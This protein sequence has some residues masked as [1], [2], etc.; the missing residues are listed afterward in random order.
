M[1]LKEISED[2]YI[3]DFY[4]MQKIKYNH[5]KFDA[6]ICTDNGALDYMQKYGKNIFPKVPVVCCGINYVDEKEIK[7]RDTYKIVMENIDI[8]AMLNNISIL[9]PKVKSLVIFGGNTSSGFNDLEHMKSVSQNYKHRF[10]FEFYEDTPIEKVKDIILS[11]NKDTAAIFM[12]DPMRDATGNPK[13]I[14]NI[15]DEFFRDTP[16]PIF[17]FWDFDLNYGILGGNLTSGYYQGETASKIALK[18][19]SGDSLSNID[20]TWASPNRYMFDY[21][22]LKKFNVNLKNLPK[23]SII[24][25][26]PF[27][28]YEKY[29]KLVLLIFLVLIIT[30]LMILL[31]LKK[32]N[33]I[34]LSNSYDELSAVYEELSATEEELRAQYDELQ[35]NEDLIRTREEIYRLA[36]N[37]ANDAIWQWNIKENY[38][39]ISDK[40][41]EFTGHDLNLSLKDIYDNFVLEEDKE[42]IKKHLISTIYGRENYYKS[43]I[44]LKTKNDNI[45]WFL[46]KGEV[47]RDN[48]GN[49]LMMAGSFTDISERKIKE[50]QIEK[51][52][53]YDSLT[54]LPNRGLFMK[55]LQEQ[56][57]INKLENKTGAIM[58]L[59]LDE[60]KKIN[61]TLGHFKGDCLLKIISYKLTFSIPK[62][63]T[64]ARFGG[65]EFL[66]LIPEVNNKMELE[67]LANQLLKIIKE[68]F[69]LGD[70]V[71]YVTSSI[72]IAVFP[73]DG[74]SGDILLKN[75][76]T[77]MYNAKES[78]KNRYCFFKNIMEKEI[79]RKA[80]VEN[81]LRN[82]LEN[83]EFQVYYQPQINMKSGEIIG[84]EALLRWNSKELGNISPMEFI[85]LAEKTGFIIP[86]G[87]WVLETV[88]KQNE[89]WKDKGYKYESIAVNVSMV[90][91]IQWDFIEN[92]KNILSIYNVSPNSLELEITENSLL[93]CTEENFK[94]IEDLRALGIKISLD[95]FGTGYSSL[96]YLRMFSINTV[97][98]DKS[99]ISDIANKYEQKLITEV[100]INLSHK[101]D[102]KVVAEGIENKE[103]LQL[104][105]SM[106][107]DFA[108]G[109]YFSKAANYVDMENLLKNNNFK[110]LIKD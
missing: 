2:A 32:K 71:N 96:N 35:K 14:A 41:T 34:A 18:I 63:C 54:G 88:C 46:V 67:D 11:K 55:K 103:Q 59:D 104:L 94:K 82:A 85:P 56:I 78:G 38:F 76:D 51:M 91:F 108:Q 26:K 22:Q 37:G 61:D 1:N 40:W 15:K 43:E 5:I 68:P 23:E 79:L 47:L 36:V 87:N 21:K 7:D 12:T 107:C 81:N 65:D 70:S 20:S 57:E 80:S 49:P 42:E 77:A 53:F 110:A 66:L 58:F 24:I 86:I 28:F 97:K 101:L 19:V 62:N 75:A 50:N 48:L 10:N 102:Y 74:E 44:R 84:M 33:Q 106:D 8:E 27:S 25:N 17:S 83:N 31:R 73:N 72:G 93:E 52:A 64:A 16:I 109:F 69:N 3:K 89:L 6:I 99:F 60:F 92:I 95:D 100:I 9:Q 39:F 4:N 105:Q 29:K 98:I 90:Q 30:F 13:Y 45:K